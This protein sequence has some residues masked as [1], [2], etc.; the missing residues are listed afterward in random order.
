MMSPFLSGGVL[1]ASLV[2]GQSGTP[3]AS[4]GTPTTVPPPPSLST[5]PTPAAPVAQPPQRGPIISFFTRE[6]RPVLSKITG[7]SAAQRPDGNAGADDQ[8][9][10]SA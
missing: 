3:P 6:D 9:A 10:V 1:A 7:W 4:F 8:G 2:L 5:T